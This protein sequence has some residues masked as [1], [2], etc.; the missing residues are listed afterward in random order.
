[1]KYLFILAMLLT[2]CTTTENVT[3][4]QQHEKSWDYLTIEQNLY[5]DS[6][7][8]LM[9]RKELPKTP[10]NTRWVRVSSL[11]TQ[12]NLRRYAL[13]GKVFTTPFVCILHD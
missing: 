2:A 9:W 4:T 1:M 12:Y 3:V 6:T 7:Q 5:N 13:D 10:E 11:G 8:I